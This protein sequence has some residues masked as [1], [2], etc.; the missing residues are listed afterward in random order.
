MGYVLNL[1][2]DVFANDQGKVNH[3]KNAAVVK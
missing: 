1:P 3:T 2:L